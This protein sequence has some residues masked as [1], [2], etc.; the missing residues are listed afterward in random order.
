ML[1]GT[2]WLDDISARLLGWKD[3]EERVRRYGGAEEVGEEVD[4][5]VAPRKEPVTIAPSAI[6][7]LNAPPEMPP[8]ANAPATTVNRSPGRRTNFRPFP[9]QSLRAAR[10]RRART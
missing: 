10:P 6:A 3:V 5:D 1:P 7:G 4:P 2:C 8:T 9:A